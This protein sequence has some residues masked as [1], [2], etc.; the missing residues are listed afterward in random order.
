LQKAIDGD[1]TRG[2]GAA[3]IRAFADAVAS[4]TG[5]TEGIDWMP[6]HLA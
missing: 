2:G 4:E 1:A 6:I 5:D 3:K